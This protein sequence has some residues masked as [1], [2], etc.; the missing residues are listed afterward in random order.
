MKT[1]FRLAIV[2]TAV[3]VVLSGVGVGA[4]IYARPTVRVTLQ[5]RNLDVRKVVRILERQTGRTIVVQ[6]NVTGVVTLNAKNL[7]LEKALAI[8]GEQT[9]SQTGS[10]YPLYSN[11]Q[12]LANLKSIL[13][14]ESPSFAGW[15]NLQRN[16]TQ[17][18]FGGAGPR[19]E[20]AANGTPQTVSLNISFEELSFAALAFSRLTPARVVV[21]DGATNR[22]SVS[23]RNAPVTEAVATLAKK[24]GRKWTRLYVLSRGGPARGSG[25]ASTMSD[26]EAVQREVL[27]DE[28]LA[29]L[30]PDEREKREEAEVE[31]QKRF[32]EM[33][34]MTP[35]ERAQSRAQT[36]PPGGSQRMLERLKE[37]TPEQRAAQKRQMTQMRAATVGGSGGVIP[38]MTRN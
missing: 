33:K 36:Q 1:K 9:F 37:S 34:N 24:A 32:A 30:P 19:R 10:I 22:V 8:I 20:E 28:L 18:R 35:A 5:V 27:N 11:S 14:G 4:W 29:T 6:S 25:I 17:L 31:R 23:L 2:M 26:E 16:G 13:N 7:P 15:T 12:A 38:P 21:E 3:A